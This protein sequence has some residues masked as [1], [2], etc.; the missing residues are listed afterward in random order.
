MEILIDAIPQET[1]RSV[2]SQIGGRTDEDVSACRIGRRKASLARERYT[3][4]KPVS[5]ANTKASDKYING[6][7]FK[8]Y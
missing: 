8:F 1:S 2:R 5:F 6:A 4:R 7:C 3:R